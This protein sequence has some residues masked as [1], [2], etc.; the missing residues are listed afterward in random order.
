M[1]A[2]LPFLSSSL[3][4]TVF[5][6]LL[7]TLQHTH[8]SLAE[9]FASRFM[10]SILQYARIFLSC[11]F[12]TRGSFNDHIGSCTA[13]SWLKT[14]IQKHEN[15]FLRSNTLQCGISLEKSVSTERY[16][17]FYE[18]IV[19]DWMITDRTMF[20]YGCFARAKVNTFLWISQF[21]ECCYHFVTVELCKPFCQ[22]LNQTIIQSLRVKI[23]RQQNFNVPL[24][25][26]NEIYQ[27]G[28]LLNLESG[29]NA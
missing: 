4:S 13:D 11:F 24:L 12:S 1:M 18:T 14:W 9:R 17:I 15:T 7:A 26:S 6:V 2:N 10:N 5:F 16:I 8:S 22:H 29:K 27:F 19:I 20:V 21:W 28:C 23:F 3:I 25:L